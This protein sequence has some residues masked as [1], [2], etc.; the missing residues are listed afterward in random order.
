M[1]VNGKNIEMNEYVEGFVAN[2]TA[3]IVK[4]LKGVDYLKKIDLKQDKDGISITVNNQDISLTPFPDEMISSTLK[5]MLQPLKETS[6]ARTIHI[7][8][9]VI[10]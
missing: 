10:G 5:G 4:S 1:S 3:G 6:D 7:V 8:V 9:D 2:I